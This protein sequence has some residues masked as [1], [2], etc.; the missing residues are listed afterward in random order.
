MSESIYDFKVKNIEGNE[1]SM[2]DYK[3]KA[4]LIVNTASACG[5]TPQYEGL[6]KVYDKYKDQGLVVL[7]FPCNQ[8][9]AQEKGSETEIKE[10]CD[11][12]FNI[13]FPLFSKIN[14][15]G[16][17][18]DPL[19]KFLK[20]AAPGLLGTEKIKWNFTKFLVDKKGNVIERFASV[21]KPESIE[22]QIKEIL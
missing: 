10:F 1:V 14:V 16:D 8:F 15:N 18:A 3:D 2:G 7:A 22:D 12:K 17:D 5:F 20:K 21:T 19:Y 6:Q 9:G 13:K 11:L 4:M